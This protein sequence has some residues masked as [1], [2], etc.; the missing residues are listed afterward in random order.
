[1]WPAAAR[2]ARP[3]ADYNVGVSE[4]GPV[5]A[6]G[7]GAGDADDPGAPFEVDDPATAAELRAVFD[8]YE[9]ALVANEREVLDEL[10]W[11]SR[12]TVRYGVADVQHGGG[13]VAR[14]RRS[15]ARQTAPR[16]LHDT[17]VQTFG[18]TFGVVA[19]EFTLEDGT[20]GRQSQTW[21]RFAAGWRVVAAH[22]SIGT[23]PAGAR[24]SDP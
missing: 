6:N 2:G 16:R 10:F 19:T 13:A 22:V 18:P 24:T 8:R 15:L 9:A 14:F 4:G 21:V 1:M 12:L 23:L 11:P 5:G 20:E 3:R 17:V 7:A